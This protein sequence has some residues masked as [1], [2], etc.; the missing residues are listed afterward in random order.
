VSRA[1]AAHHE[2]YVARLEA[3]HALPKTLPGAA[4]QT[5][6]AHVRACN[7]GETDSL[8]TEGIPALYWANAIQKLKPVRVYTHRVNL[9][10]VQ[11][12]IGQTEEGLY[13]Q[14]GVSS[15]IPRPGHEVDGFVLSQVEPGVFKFTRQK[16]N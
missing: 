7:A 11:R 1:A 2:V 14:V 10:V 12:Q 6:A 5:Y 4:Y 9:V 3:S 13:I 15:Y 16:G 8:A